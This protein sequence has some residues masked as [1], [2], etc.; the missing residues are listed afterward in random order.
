MLHADDA[1]DAEHE[2]R[3]KLVSRTRDIQFAIPI[4]LLSGVFLAFCPTATAQASSGAATFKSKCQLCHGAD[5]TGDTTLGKQLQA[6]NLRSKDVQKKTDAEL[7]KV[8]HDGNGNMPPFADQLS[9]DQIAQVIRFV[10]AL[11]KTAKK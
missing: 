4:F 8:I 5:G 10:R 3:T 7:H 2:R 9:D 11:G 6:A 1:R